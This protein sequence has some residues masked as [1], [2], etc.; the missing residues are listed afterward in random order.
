MGL[1]FS[2]EPLY[3]D[4]RTLE[5]FWEVNQSANSRRVVQV[6]EDYIYVLPVADA[7]TLGGIRSSTSIY[8][9]SSGV[10]T[11]ARGTDTSPGIV[12]FADGVAVANGTPGLAIDAAQLKAAIAGLTGGGGG[13]GGINAISGLAPIVIDSSIPSNP[14]V[15]V[16]P[17][18]AAARGVVQLADDAAVAA[19]AAGRVVDAAQL[20]AKL[21]R[22]LQ[23]LPPLP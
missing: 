18:T 11:V 9:D 2:H 23:L 16:L 3:F 21:D 12:Q 20:Q 17:A 15:T 10:A 5:V 22:D 1:G 8:V 4:A 13:G 19:G 6:A 7:V 14:V